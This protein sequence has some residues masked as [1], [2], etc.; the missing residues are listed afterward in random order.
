VPEDSVT[1]LVLD[2]GVLELVDPEELLLVPEPLAEDPLLEDFSSLR[3]SSPRCS[4]S[5]RELL[6]RQSREP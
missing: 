6:L 2:A 4:P 3:F 1:V 5:L